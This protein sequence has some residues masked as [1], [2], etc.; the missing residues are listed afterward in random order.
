MGIKR[1]KRCDSKRAVETIE[2]DASGR[3]RAGGQ[4]WFAG[5][6][7]R[8]GAQVALSRRI[9]TTLRSTCLLGVPLLARCDRKSDRN[10]LIWHLIVRGAQPAS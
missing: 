10:C 4:R 8:T 1:E 6:A 5:S 3:V 2:A 7:Q 9:H